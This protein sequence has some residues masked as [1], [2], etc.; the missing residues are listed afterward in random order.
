MLSDSVSVGLAF[1]GILG[2]LKLPDFAL[3]RKYILSEH[4]EFMYF[5]FAFRKIW[6]F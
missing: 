2:V 4:S 3:K 5:R 1:A 6:K